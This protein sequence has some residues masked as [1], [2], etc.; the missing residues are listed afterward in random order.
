MKLAFLTQPAAFFAGSGYMLCSSILG[1]GWFL[2]ARSA[3]A[4]LLAL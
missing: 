2:A 3:D 1:M 4:Y